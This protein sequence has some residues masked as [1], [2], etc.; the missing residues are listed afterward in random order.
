M[1]YKPCCTSIYKI[2]N[3]SYYKLIGK[4]WKLYHLVILNFTTGEAID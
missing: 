3:F 1:H 4:K 2:K